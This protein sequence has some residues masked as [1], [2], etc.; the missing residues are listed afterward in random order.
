VVVVVVVQVIILVV[1]VIAVVKY[2]ST[3]PDAGYPDR[4]LSGSAWAIV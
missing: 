2:N 1:V 3:Y 4:K